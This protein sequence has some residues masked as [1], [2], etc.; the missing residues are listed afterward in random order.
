M[1]RKEYTSLP[2]NYP[3]CEQSGCPKEA[4]CLHQVAYSMMLDFDKYEEHIN[5]SA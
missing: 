2:T 1:P 4:T 5:W 3:V